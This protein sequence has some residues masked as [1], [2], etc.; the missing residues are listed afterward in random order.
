MRKAAGRKSLLEKDMP[1]FAVKSARKMISAV[2]GDAAFFKLQARHYFIRRSVRCV[3]LRHPRT[4][5]EKILWIKFY[6]NPERF[7]PY[8][9]KYTVRT[10]VRDTRGSEYL[11]RLLGVYSSMED[12][13]FGAL[14]RAFV[15]KATHGSG[16]N[17]I[18][19]DKALVDWTEAKSKMTAWLKSNYYPKGGEANYKPLKGRIVIDEYIDDPSG[20]LK[21]YKFYCYHGEPRYIQV[22]SDRFADHR[23]DIYDLH[24]NKLP[25][26]MDYANLLHPV[27]KPDH[28]ETMLELCR[29][30]SGGFAFVR[31]DLYNVSEC[32]LFGEMTFT[33]HIGMVLITPCH[34]D[35]LLG[36]HLDLARHN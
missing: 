2:L 17:I 13:D 32:I 28:F 19:K 33:P 11:V 25:M 26:K 9:D 31:I 18:V 6:G 36:S 12:I 10:F 22:D 34:Y 3:H 15:M 27:H 23:R 14:P 24:W 20:D 8:V 35:Y 4:F 1:S 21:N 16:W 29:K 5:C 7:A 30:L